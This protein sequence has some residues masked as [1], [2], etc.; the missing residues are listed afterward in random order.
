MKRDEIFEYVKNNF[1]A[2]PEYLW[3]KYPTYAVFRNKGN[4]KWFGAVMTVPKSVLGL[5]SDGEIEILDVKCVPALVSM[6]LGEKGFLPAYHMNKNN[7]I[8][9]LLDGS[10]GKERICE[11][12]KASYS[13]TS[14]AKKLKG[15]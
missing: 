4:N 14:P 11:L 13:L 7:W 3:L 15:K 9:I 5:G 6:L 2:E 10:V 1:G 8:T 12:I